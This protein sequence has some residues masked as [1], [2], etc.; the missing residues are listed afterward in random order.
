MATR[1]ITPR[2]KPAQ[3]IQAVPAIPNYTRPMA[4]VT[5]L[6]FMWGFITC[7]N[8]ILVPHLK[9]LF[10]LSYAKVMLVQFAFFSAYFFFSWPWSKVV[11][12]I[13]YQKTMVAGLLTMA[14][15]AF[16]F[17]PAASIV[18][19]PL[20]LTALIILGGGI[21]GL[22][23]AANPYV[24][25]LGKPKTAS[26]RMDLTQAFNSLGTTIA[27]KLGGLLIL[28]VVP[29]AIAQL[30]KLTP[31]ALQIYRVQ[32]AASVKM[33][34]TVIGIALLLLAVLIG[35]SKL[36][37][38]NVSEKAPGQIGWRFHLEAPQSLARR[39]R[40][41]RL[42][43]RGSFHRKLPGELF[44][45]ARDRESVRSY[46]GG[47]CFFLLGRRH[48]WAFYRRGTLT[49]DGS[50][51]SADSSARLLRRPGHCFHVAGR[52]YGDVDDHRRRVLQL[53][54]VPH[55]L[56]VGG[57]G[58]WGLNGKWLRRSEYGHRRRRDSAGHTRSYCRPYWT[59]SCVH[60]ARA[61]LPV[62]PVLRSERIG[63]Q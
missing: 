38:L 30:Q 11:N 48:D 39:D 22:Q 19:Y 54:H 2:S 57:S 14:V 4:V 58:T 21:T 46:R 32:Q 63:A 31:E 43:G 17:L 18:S 41:F 56:H 47:L 35:F 1:E 59:S 26:S 12:K 15:G 16:L 42:R 20:F 25:A 44:R 6:F 34:Y 9:S 24:V 52:I 7:L 60:S 50:K 8:D 51:I 10:D 40:D 62:H 61:L 27:P 33:P 53:D 29:L 28:S 3:G 5:T 13:G 45:L 37:K 36:P 55:H 49:A 23:V